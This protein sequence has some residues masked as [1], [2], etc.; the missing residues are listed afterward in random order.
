MTPGSIQAVFRDWSRAGWLRFQH[1]VTVLEARRLDQVAEVIREV[2]ARVE[3]ER[4]FAAGFLAYES[5]P[6]FDP[7]LPVRLD[8]DFPPAWFA[9][10]RHVTDSAAP[11]DAP[12]PGT[13]PHWQAEISPEHYRRDIATIRR[14]LAAG[15]T[16]QVNYTY[17]LRATTDVRPEDLFVSLLDDPAPPHAAFLDT[18]DWS[19]C[20]VS[21]ELFLHLDGDRLLSRPMKG[22]APRGRW[23]EQDRLRADTLRDSEKERAENV[24]IVDM[25]RND[26]GRVAAPG[27]VDVPTLFAVE[28]YPTVWQM[29]STVRA[30]TRAPL[31]HILHACFPASSI[32]GA[33]KRRTMQIIRELETSPRRVYTGAMGYVLPGRKACFNVAI[34]TALLHRPSG[35][36]EYGIGGGIVWD[37]DPDSELQESRLKARVLQP[38]PR[39]RFELLET[40]LWDPEHGFTLLD[41][42]LRRIADSAKYFAFRFDPAT[43]RA[44]LTGAARGLPPIPHRVRMTVSRSGACECRAT[45]LPSPAP[46]FADLPLARH[47]VDSSNVFLYHKTTHRRTYQDALAACPDHSDVLLYNERGEVTEST[48]A[49]VAMEIDGALCT[50][51]LRCGLLPGTQRAELLDRG[52]LQ[53]GVLTLE[54]VRRARRLFLMNSLR[55]LHPVTL[56]GADP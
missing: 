24:M 20:S 18:G 35:A 42:H 5:G 13:R 32:T 21:P 51:P 30:R 47:P 36:L 28:Q 37:S 55:G 50:P 10:F 38:R 6:A 23:S 34:R 25:V 12:L 54:D 39:H 14:Y 53:E 45:A 2:E 27:S 33:P 19:L 40:L 41:R 49:N 46:R 1:P 26:L 43:V 7:S 17:R 9:L 22:T 8:P 56:L 29:T 3:N 44:A 15:D 4:L 31:L 16:Y 11:P 52:R 48:I